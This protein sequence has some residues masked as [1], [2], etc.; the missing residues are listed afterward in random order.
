MKSKS[1]EK[2]QLMFNLDWVFRKRFHSLQD[3]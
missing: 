3:R 1:I 2:P